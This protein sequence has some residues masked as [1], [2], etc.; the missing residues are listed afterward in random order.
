MDP[1]Q[2]NNNNNSPIPPFMDPNAALPPANP[3]GTPP[4]V[5][6]IIANTTSDTPNVSPAVENQLPPNPVN[7]PAAQA[8][9]TTAWDSNPT[10]PSNQ[11]NTAPPAA[12]PPP[13]QINPSLPS[14]QPGLNNQPNLTEPAAF[15]NFNS[16]LNDPTSSLDNTLNLSNMGA[17]VP[18]SQAP[19]EPTPTFIPNQDIPGAA[20]S[21]TLPPD[22]EPTMVN[23]PN[24][25]TSSQQDF[26]VTTNY[27]TPPQAAD[28]AGSVGF[29][30]VAQETAPTDLSQLTNQEPQ[31][32]QPEVYI[33]PVSA[34]DNLVVPQQQPTPE[35]IKPKH[36]ISLGKI[37]IGVSAL[38]LLIVAGGSGYYFL[39]I[40]KTVKTDTSVPAT[41]S[42]QPPLTN[43][44]I[45]ATPTATPQSQ[46][47]VA[48]GSASFGDIINTSSPSAS[49]KSTS[50]LDILKK[51]QKTSPKPSATP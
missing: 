15:A 32:S 49:P 30:P 19:T 14:P 47:T 45:K 48:T 33:P 41:V 24:Q 3:T 20:P 16:P 36:G 1:K 38:V 2:T 18:S 26:N 6:P 29:Q 7:L 28:V 25:N 27:P 40:G 43:P 10:I 31:A 22:P 46:E 17:A 11:L 39:G 42:D 50:A 8:L 13:T 35:T 51:R 12:T 21:P 34:T 4:I 9:P 37:V 5:E 23:I 44:P